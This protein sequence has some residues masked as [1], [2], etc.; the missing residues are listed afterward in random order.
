MIVGE[1]TAE[2]SPLLSV[3]SYVL[4]GDIS[5]LLGFHVLPVIVEPGRRVFSQ[6]V[7]MSVGH[8]CWCLEISNTET[9]LRPV[10]IS[11]PSIEEV[12]YFH[13]RKCDISDSLGEN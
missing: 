12:Q 8:V 9:S 11:I 3:G 6:Q 5:S 13:W 1:R 10:F 4:L 7:V 2:R